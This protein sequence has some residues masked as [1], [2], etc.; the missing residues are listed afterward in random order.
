MCFRQLGCES[1]GGIKKADRTTNMLLHGLAVI[2]SSIRVMQGR[3][4]KVIGIVN[5]FNVVGREDRILQNR[6]QRVLTKLFFLVLA[7]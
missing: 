2:P 5:R 6:F 7:L 1:E 4:V 3:T